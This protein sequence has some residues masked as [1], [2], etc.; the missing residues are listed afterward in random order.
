MVH[1]EAPKVVFSKSKQSQ[2]IV[3]SEKKHIP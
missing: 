2:K 1:N 3:T